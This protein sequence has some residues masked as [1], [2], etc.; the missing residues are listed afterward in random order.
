MN[1]FI[2][3]GFVYGTV[4]FIITMSLLFLIWQNNEDI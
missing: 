4:T 3:D 1:V 2:L